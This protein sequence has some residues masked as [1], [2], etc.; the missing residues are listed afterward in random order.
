MTNSHTVHVLF[1]FIVPF[2]KVWRDRQGSGLADMAAF[3]GRLKAAADDYISD[4][5]FNIRL[6][7]ESTLE[8]E[9]LDWKPSLPP[10]VKF[11][12]RF[13]LL[14]STVNIDLQKLLE[15]TFPDSPK[16]SEFSGL[17]EVGIG[18]LS[19][20]LEKFTGDLE[21]A[22]TIAK[23]GS[24]DP[25]EVFL[26]VDRKLVER[27]P[28]RSSD[29]NLVVDH[30]A[31]IGWPK[32]REVNI[33]QAWQWL[34][35]VPGLETGVPQGSVGRAISALSHV[36]KGDFD[37]VNLM[38]C[39][40]GIEALYLKGK[41]G[42]SEQLFEKT[43]ALLGPV[44]EHKRAFRGLYEYRSRFVH[45]DLDTPL[46]YTPYDATK[47]YEEFYDE[48]HDTMLRA[49]SLLLATLQKMVELDI[50]SLDFRYSLEEKD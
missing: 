47:E 13:L 32:L 10:G 14:E 41:Q 24:L 45:G 37:V 6:L 21:I 5:V 44:H 18:D 40:I 3:S 1:Q 28:R 36:I 8:T 11:K 38:W 7:D 29:F 48:T 4:R 9:D 27:I 39:M 16:G 23:P 20:V 42:I 17:E 49:N 26:Y 33:E 31:E 35:K 12:M 2:E 15:N 50:Y 19:T 34:S 43:Q 25:R 30:A 46:A 22:T